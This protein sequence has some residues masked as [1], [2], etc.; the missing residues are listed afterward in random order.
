MPALEAALAQQLV[1]LILKVVAVQPTEP[2]VMVAVV[3]EED[4]REVH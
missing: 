2:Q 4:Q 1:Q 3:A